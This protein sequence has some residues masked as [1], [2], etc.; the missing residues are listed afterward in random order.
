MDLSDIYKSEPDACPNAA[1][2]RT[3][4]IITLGGC[5]LLWKSQLQT[6]IS[7]STLEAEYNALSFAMR[8]L[9]PIKRLVVKIAKAI[10]I[11][12]EIHANILSQVFEDNNGALIVT[13][14][15][16]LTNC[17]KNFL[18][19]WHFIRDEVKRSEIQVVKIDMNEQLG[20]FLTKGLP[21][22]SFEQNRIAIQG[23]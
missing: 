8:T 15:Q 10:S 4:Y 2:S 5:P 6:E 1:R 13:T 7:L 11:L 17:T 23:W 9:I 21:C 22:E 14:K 16:C 18:V 19:K 12:K 20:D 3:R